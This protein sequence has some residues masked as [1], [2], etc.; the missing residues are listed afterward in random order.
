MYRDDCCAS[1]VTF[2]SYA[3]LFA[4][5][6]FL[7]GA[8]ADLILLCEL[9]LLVSNITHS[10]DLIHN[11]RHSEVLCPYDNSII[12][13]RHQ[14]TLFRAFIKCDAEHWGIT[15]HVHNLLLLE[16]KS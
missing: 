2:Y 10:R 7:S 15:H 14:H 6:L 3:A 8:D 4:L 12:L 1:C 16:W 11:N 13:P 5:S 9:I